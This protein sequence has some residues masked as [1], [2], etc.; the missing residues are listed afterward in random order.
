[1]ASMAAETC[2]YCLQ[3]TNQ[4]QNLY[5]P[6]C[7]NGH[8]AHLNC[9]MNQFESN[10]RFNIDTW[11]CPICRAPA[12]YSPDSGIPS[13]NQVLR[14]RFPRRIAALE[15]VR[16]E[17]VTPIEYSDSSGES[18]DEPD[19]SQNEELTIEDRLIQQYPFLDERYR[20]NEGGYRALIMNGLTAQVRM[21]GVFHPRH[22]DFVDT[23]D[24]AHMGAILL[25]EWNN[26][27]N[28]ARAYEGEGDMEEVHS[29]LSN[30]SPFF[31]A[32]TMTILL[33]WASG[34]WNLDSDQVILLTNMRRRAEQADGVL[35]G[36]KR[37]KKTRRKR[38]RGG[39]GSQPTT[40]RK[41][42]HKKPPLPLKR[43]KITFWEKKYRGENEEGITM[44]VMQHL[45]SMDLNDKE[46]EKE[47]LEVL[48]YYLNDYKRIPENQQDPEFKKNLEKD[49]TIF[50][51]YVNNQ[52][53]GKRRKRKTR[54][55][56][57]GM[58]EPST[59]PR[60]PKDNDR[61]TNRYP[62]GFTLPPP[63]VPVRIA[64]Q[65]QQARMMRR[66]GSRERLRDRHPG[67]RAPT[68]RMINEYNEQLRRSQNSRVRNVA[69][70]VLEAC[71]GSRCGLG[72]RRKKKRRKTR[73][74]KNRKRRTKK[75]SRR[76]KR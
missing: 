35:T 47:I 48:K 13:L 24:A 22:A 69:G 63:Q 59:P 38:R 76:K 57:G 65:P 45:T 66:R 68:Q 54:K 19:D 7:N 26:M 12:Y 50:Q 30:Q 71:T 72:G 62:P 42:P 5:G 1:M 55:K 11:T 70:D 46:A 9:I 61:G 58:E 3:V 37:K 8:R 14:Q 51:N 27:Y 52:S 20:E 49:I 6:I 29:S 74:K 23:V 43:P 39:V 60:P 10:G 15:A 25:T 56:K 53:G 33:G 32:L 31:R 4:G 17:H 28:Q 16:Y 75:K 41:G 67:A 34:L 18:E 64:G 2:P 21:R 36:G 73:R 40:P 44:N